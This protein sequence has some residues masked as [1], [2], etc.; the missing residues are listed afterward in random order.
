MDSN[1]VNKTRNVENFCKARYVFLLLWYRTICIP[2]VD[3]CIPFFVFELVEGSRFH[4]LGG[5][6]KI[7]LFFLLD[8]NN[9]VTVLRIR[10]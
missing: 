7:C 6:L 4:C 10:I 1:K 8:P 3:V 2:N 5:L 9:L